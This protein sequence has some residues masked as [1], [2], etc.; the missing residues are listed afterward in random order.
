V[1][2]LGVKPSSSH[3]FGSNRQPFL[4]FFVIVRG[5]KEANGCPLQDFSNPTACLLA[6]NSRA[7]L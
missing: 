2:T 7:K 4:F 5:K 3:D 1:L 6:Q